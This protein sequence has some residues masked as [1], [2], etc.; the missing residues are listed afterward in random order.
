[1]WGKK[2]EGRDRDKW[3]CQDEALWRM[4]GSEQQNERW[5]GNEEI[6]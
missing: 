2:G 1:M 4:W 5:E 6:Q 3:V